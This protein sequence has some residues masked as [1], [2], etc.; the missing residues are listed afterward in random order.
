MQKSALMFCRWIL[1]IWDKI[2]SQNIIYPKSPIFQTQRFC[3]LKKWSDH[4][5][6]YCSRSRIRLKDTWNVQS[7]FMKDETGTGVICATY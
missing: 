6:M 4:S 2:S 5:E 1:M 7:C 3:S